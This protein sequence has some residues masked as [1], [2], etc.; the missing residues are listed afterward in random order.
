MPRL[1]YTHCAIFVHDLPHM[2]DFYSRVLGYPITDRGELEYSQADNLP[3]ARL[4]FLS[5]NPDE[6]HQ[7]ILVA[8]RPDKLSFNP[9][10]HLA[11]RVGSLDEVRRAY[12]VIKG[13]DVT[14]I[15]PVTHGNAWSLYFRDPEGNR[16]EIYTPTPWHVPQP[17]RVA[18][19]LTLSD[20]AIVEGTREQLKDLP[21]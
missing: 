3:T 14:E 20:E 9:I 10:N 7:V 6:H 5:L 21:G 1:E 16:L 12:Q 8:G 18:I 13:E 17:F 4:V 11:F 15:R 2:E 19:D